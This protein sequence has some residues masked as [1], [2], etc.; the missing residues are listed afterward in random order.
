MPIEIQRIDATLLKILGSETATGQRVQLPFTVGERVSALVTAQLGDGRVMLEVRGRSLEAR[1][2]VPLAPGQALELEVAGLGPE[3]T[4]RVTS[5][6]PAVSERNF[7]LGVLNTAH[8]AGPP[9]PPADVGALLALVEQDVAHLPEAQRHEV[10]RLLAPLRAASGPEVL[11]VELKHVLENGG[12]LL[13][14]RVRAWLQQA[15][16]PM[17]AD[18]LPSSVANDL[19]VLLGLLG[20]AIDRTAPPPSAD[21]QPTASMPVPAAL[22]MGGIAARLRQAVA[23]ASGPAASVTS[24]L[25][26]EDATLHPPASSEA[27]APSPA[28]KPGAAAAARVTSSVGAGD[29]LQQR[30]LRLVLKEIEAG[31]PQDRTAVDALRAEHAHLKDEL[32]ARQ[33]DAAYHW[34]RDGTLDTHWPLA[35]GSQTVQAWFRFHRGLE[36]RDAADARTP[37]E[38]F[39]FDVALDPPGL[40]PLRAHVAWADSR[41]RVLFFVAHQPTA[42]AISAELASLTTALETSGFAAVSASVSVDHARSHLEPMPP[43]QAPAGGSIFSLRA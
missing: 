37:A 39:S 42:D 19:K 3:I 16:T 29:A 43:P 21:S 24:G 14:S 40:G 34:V 1:S 26:P 7:A 4:M 11:A 38:A 35:F 5:G 22:L 28:A 20:R 33:V 36:D 8:R 27:G 2:A 17:P 30:A 9:V 23:A 10:A 31:A 18:T 13:E 15:Q 41:L 25:P 32:L 12:L 6:G